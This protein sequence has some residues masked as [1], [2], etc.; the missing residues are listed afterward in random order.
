M[1]KSMMTLV[2]MLVAMVMSAQTSG[3]KISAKYKKGDN[4]LYRM[5]AVTNVMGKSI[6]VVSESRFVVTEASS[7]GYVI[8]NTLE[9]M[10]SD[11]A[12][13]DLVGRMMNATTECLKGLKT[14]VVTDA[15]GKVTGIK[16]REEINKKTGEY[17]DKVFDELFVQLPAEA[18]QI[19]TKDKL[20]ATVMEQM[21]ETNLIKSMIIQPS[22]LALNGL[23]I[24]TGSTDT[25][26]DVSG[27]KLKNTYTL[28]TPDATKVKVVGKSEMTKDD[29]KTVN[30][31]EADYRK[32]Y[33]GS[34]YAKAP[35]SQKLLKLFLPFSSTNL[36]IVSVAEFNFFSQKSINFIASV[37]FLI[38]LSKSNSPLS[39][40]LTIV[41]SSLT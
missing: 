13:D 34:A 27:F 19:L 18:T 41:S 37:Y 8:E 36:L 29:M 1:K 20:K 31:L 23:T 12:P 16:N 26:V 9:K 5:T 40:S 10:E 7:K 6:N 22:P 32:I 39:S 4:M 24:S 21:T 11:A 2:L 17:L 3:V 14:S 15:D 28:V 35:K 30:S 38:D 33:S 25:G